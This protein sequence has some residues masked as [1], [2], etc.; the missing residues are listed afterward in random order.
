MKIEAVLKPL[1]F[2][3]SL[4]GLH[5]QKRSNKSILQSIYCIV[6]VLGNFCVACRENEL[7]LSSKRDLFL[8]IAALMK[9]NVNNASFALIIVIVCFKAESSQQTL[10]IFQ[11]I[12]LLFEHRRLNVHLRSFNVYLT[13]NICLILLLSFV[14]L[15]SLCYILNDATEAVKYH[16]LYCL[17]TNFCNVLLLQVETYV[18]LTGSFLKRV[19]VSNIASLGSIRSDFPTL[20]VREIR[21]NYAAF[22]A[23]V[24]RKLYHASTKMNEAFSGPVLLH[25]ANSFV[26]VLST[27]FFAKRGLFYHGKLYADRNCFHYVFMLVS[28]TLCSLHLFILCYLC[29]RAYS[30]HRQ[31]K[32]ALYNTKNA[33]PKVSETDILSSYFLNFSTHAASFLQV[34][35]L[36]LQFLHGNIAFHAGGFF[37]INFNLLTMVII[38]K[39]THNFFKT[40]PI[41]VFNSS[42]VEQ[43]TSTY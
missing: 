22:T 20:S 8:Q 4:F 23:L 10:R 42:V 29:E 26:A 31:A 12:L 2:L 27:V 6:L 39:K 18:F 13:V 33:N 32:Q 30:E 41:F 35:Q 38:N 21:Q 36:S 17:P 24:H 28:I 1:L 7:N 14:Q 34:F 43:L 37:T 11:E 19:R 3:S 40:R 5:V 15:V 25:V 9:N 16:V